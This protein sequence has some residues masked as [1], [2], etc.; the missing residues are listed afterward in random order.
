MLYSRRHTITFARTT[1]RLRAEKA[2][3]SWCA[4]QLLSFSLF[5]K[6]EK[7]RQQRSFALALIVCYRKDRTSMS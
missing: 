3:C 1:L 5:P 2:R 7:P 4:L 6:N